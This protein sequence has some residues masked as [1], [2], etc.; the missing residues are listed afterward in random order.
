MHAF[1]LT[2][3]AIDPVDAVDPRRFAFPPQQDEQ[4]PIPEPAALV[5]QRL[6]PAAQLGVGP[7]SRTDSGLSFG[8][9]AVTVQ[10]RRSF[11]S[12]MLL[13][14]AIC[15]ALGGG[16]RQFFDSSSLSAFKGT[17]CGYGRDSRQ[18]SDV[19]AQI[20]YALIE[21]EN[22]LATRVDLTARFR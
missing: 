8:P 9:A 2:L 7:P 18:A 15:L 12:S 20:D 1:Y 6:Q 11:I 22:G 4:P 3:L 14:R 5:G 17:A 13:R 10:A 16:P 19:A 21:L